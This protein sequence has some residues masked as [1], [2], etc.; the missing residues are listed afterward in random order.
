MAGGQRNVGWQR[1]VILAA[2][3]TAATLTADYLGLVDWLAGLIGYG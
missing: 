3:G 1:V 2:I